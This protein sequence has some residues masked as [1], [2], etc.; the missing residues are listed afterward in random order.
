MPGILPLSHT[1]N[2]KWRFDVYYSMVEDIIVNKTYFKK[3]KAKTMLKI[4]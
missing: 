4:L 1:T 3:K 2:F